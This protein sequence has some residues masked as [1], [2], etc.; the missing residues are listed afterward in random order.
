MIKIA[1]CDD[2]KF[3][4]DDV[5]IRVMDYFDDD[6]EKF[7]IFEF[8]N[9]LNLVNFYKHA[10]MLD[11]IFMDIEVG[12]D[13]GVRAISKI[14]EIDNNVI[15][16]F[17]TSHN[18]F[19][20]DAFC[21]GAFQ[22]ISKPIDDQIFKHEIHRAVTSFISN[23]KILRVEKQRNNV[24]I[25]VNNIAY[26]ES[27]NKAVLIHMHDNTTVELVKQLSEIYEELDQLNFC[28]SHRCYIVNLTKVFSMNSNE[29]LL[30]NGNTVLV[31]RKYKDEFKSQLNNYINKV[32]I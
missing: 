25:D 18:S 7:K 32:E 21:V 10:G 27:L 8:T 28:R 2:E 14:R 9:C 16:I 31:S 22:Y 12:D 19:V 1:I 3:M 17:V 23:R 29:I 15:V 30:D 24:F 20:S 5:S 26:I 11:I 4:V 13:N 6:C